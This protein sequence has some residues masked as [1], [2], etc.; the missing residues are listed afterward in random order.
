[1]KTPYV[2][3]GGNGFDVGVIPPGPFAPAPGITDT[4]RE[5][6]DPWMEQLVTLHGS[7][8]LSLAENREVS[9]LIGERM[10]LN[11]R[12]S[13]IFER[14]RTRSRE[15]VT[16]EWELA[17][18]AVRE[19]QGKLAAHHEQIS[20]LQR[21]LNRANESKSLAFSARDAAQE[22][23]RRLSRYAQKGETDKASTLLTKREHA[24]DLAAKE[25][26]TLQQ[27]INYMMLTETKPI[28]ER[29]NQLMAEEAELNHFVTGQSFTNSLGIVVPARPPI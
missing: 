18:A 26:G 17:K 8:E 29:L 3:T 4:K 9:S 22:E 1:M 13:A 7:P 25:A 20:E 12:A 15:K 6:P 27:Q 5:L 19:Q 14:V 16:A 21:Q 24:A 23:K 11:Q 10:G 2:T 28:M